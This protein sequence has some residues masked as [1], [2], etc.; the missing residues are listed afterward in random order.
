MSTQPILTDLLSSL[1]DFPYPIVDCCLSGSHAYGF[2]SVD[3]DYDIR[4]IHVIPLHVL[5]GLSSGQ[6][7]IERKVTSGKLE[8][9]I[10]THDIRKICSLLLKHNGNILE[11]VCTTL[12]LRTAPWHSELEALARGC[13]NK[14]FAH[15]YKGF[16][17]NQHR[18]FEQQTPSEVKP[19]LYV[20]RTLLTGIHLMSTGQVEPHLER[21]H[22]IFHLAYIPDLIAQKR[23]AEHG[24]LHSADIAF[25]EREYK[26][27]VGVLEEAVA[28]SMLPDETPKGTRE[29]LN[30][31]VVG[32]R[33][34]IVP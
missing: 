11:Q 33:M 3:S 9:D 12:P 27:L 24:V 30:D 32:V 14:R 28:E 22:D 34:E 6:E 16:T 21:L 25:H 10:A 20:Y 18:L 31:F 2:S 1:P 13:I 17:Y 5:I 15:H 8:L 23:D 19:L 29:A 7:T 4:G 26:R